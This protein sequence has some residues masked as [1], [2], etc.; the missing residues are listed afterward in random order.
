MTAVARNKNTTVKKKGGEEQN[1][2]MKSL[3]KTP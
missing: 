2:P 1:K 3:R